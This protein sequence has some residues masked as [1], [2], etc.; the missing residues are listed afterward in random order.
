M[1]NCPVPKKRIGTKRTIGKRK[2]S[3]K[4]IAKVK[5][6]LERV[7]SIIAYNML[8]YYLQH[9][10][11]PKIQFAR[12]NG[13]VNILSNPFKGM[14]GWN[15]I[16]D[17]IVIEYNYSALK[18]A[19]DISNPEEL[20]KRRIREELAKPQELIK[21][22]TLSCVQA[23]EYNNLNSL[24]QPVITASPFKG[25][26][27]PYYIQSSPGMDL[28]TYKANLAPNSMPFGNLQQPIYN[29]PG[30]INPYTPNEPPYEQKVINN[31]NNN[32]YNLPKNNKEFPDQSTDQYP[33]DKYIPVEPKPGTIQ[34][35]IK[36]VGADKFFK[37]NGKLDEID[38]QY[39]N[40]RGRGML[41]FN[42]KCDD[43]NDISYE[44]N[45][46]V[47]PIIREMLRIVLGQK[48][49]ENVG[50]DKEKNKI[51][52]PES[53]FDK[54]T[55]ERGL[56]SV[57]DSGSVYSSYIT[58]LLYQI[59]DSPTF[60]LN[61]QKDLIFLAI[62]RIQADY[63]AAR[64]FY[65][66]DPKI[67]KPIIDYSN[68][69]GK[70]MNNY[71]DRLGIQLKENVKFNICKLFDAKTPINE[72]QSFSCNDNQPNNGNQSNDG[73]KDFLKGRQLT[74]EDLLS[75]LYD[76]ERLL[77]KL[78]IINYTNQ[79]KEEAEIKQKLR[80]VYKDAAILAALDDRKFPSKN[81]KCDKK[82]LAHAL[83][84]SLIN[85]H[86]YPLHSYL[87]P[88]EHQKEQSERQKQDNPFFKYNQ[89]SNAQQR[90]LRRVLDHK[91]STKRKI[92]NKYIE[93]RLIAQK[94]DQNDIFVNINRNEEIANDT[95]KTLVDAD[96]GAGYNSVFSIFEDFGAR[97]PKFINNDAIL[98][99]LKII[100][101]QA[102]ALP[103]I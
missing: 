30:Q 17:P 2:L 27:T 85:E 37:G 13:K 7:P 35:V 74:I 64:V 69:K 77:K 22:C 89:R 70:Y 59:K 95:I 41:F 65:H 56:H 6:W 4:T 40:K 73:K 102:T 58:T 91:E 43:F 92:I 98:N 83:L 49:F 86:G 11:L 48:E 66:K 36:N 29:V 33:Q 39:N 31:G 76:D 103:N 99:E 23:E 19:L 42:K 55:F 1:Y 75:G 20:I 88:T 96:I 90:P 63:Q 57:P 87:E 9:Q 18:Q 10:K 25:D 3:E 80:Q 97:D 24:E 47:F 94:T 81:E 16:E 61:S 93:N 44:E 51:L 60:A 84:K 79:G 68:L 52:L 28:N 46:G 82:Y 38:I 21:N 45:Q 34:E 50:Y 15:D 14:K 100:T 101:H 78:I 54:D 32:L 8:G 67:P 5:L 26:S 53:A 71:D 12:T 62:N 72:I